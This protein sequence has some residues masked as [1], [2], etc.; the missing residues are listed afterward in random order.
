MGAQNSV[1]GADQVLCAPSWDL[2]CRIL[3]RFLA[4]LAR[5][6][7]RSGGS[8]DLE[9]IVLRHQIAVLQPQNNRPALAEQDRALLGAVAATLSQPQRVGWFLRQRPRWAGT[10]AASPAAGPNPAGRPGA[11][12][13]LHLR[14]AASP[15][16]RDGHQQPDMGLPP[17]KRRTR[18]PRPP[19]WSLRCVENPQA[20][21]HRT[22]PAPQRTSVTWTQFLRSQAARNLFL[23]HPQ[24]LTHTRALLRDRASQFTGP[25]ARSINDPQHHAARRAPTPQRLP[26]PPTR[27][28]ATDSSTSTDMRPEQPRH[29]FGH[30]QGHSRSG[31]IRRGTAPLRFRARYVGD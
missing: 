20:A 25:T 23:D 26:E 6:A 4:L 30:P 19:R 28:D 1:V 22:R 13:A 29:N 3:Y 2:M 18:R 11:R 10:E 24:R 14:G 12:A 9:I 8:K 5:L 21:P 15:H 27:H 17:H 16:H 7:V 31:G